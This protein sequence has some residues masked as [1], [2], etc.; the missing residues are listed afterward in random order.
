VGGADLGAD[1]PHGT[2][3]LL[4][5]R[6]RHEDLFDHRS[7]VVMAES[8]PLSFLRLRGRTKS[9][10][11]WVMVILAVGALITAVGAIGSGFRTASGGRAEQL[12]Q[13]AENP[14]VGLMIGVLATVLTQSSTTTTSITVGLAAGGLPIEIAIPILFGANVGTTMTSSLVALGMAKDDVMF[15]RGF[16][17]ASVHDMYN[18]L[19]VAIFFPLELLFSPLERLSGWASA[20][21]SGEEAGP[22]GGIFEAVGTG[23]GYLIRPGVLL[24][25]WAVSPLGSIVGGVILVVAGVLLILAVITF[26]SRMLKQLLVGTA[27]KVFANALGRGAWSGVLSGTIVTMLVQSSTTTTSLAVPF[28]ATGK[29]SLSQIF[30]FVVGANIGTTLTALIAAFGF[31][32]AEGQAALGAALVHLFYNLLSAGLIMLVPWLRRLPPAAAEILARLGTENKLYV[33]GWMLMIFLVI[34][35]ILILLTVFF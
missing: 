11:D 23:V 33:L 12:F 5:C 31:T 28:A 16:A 7:T 20:R 1:V 18:L 13:F 4:K 22:V 24:L 9:V 26:I 34:P 8:Y 14:F 25:E 27:E 17:A 3:H 2:C 35:G 6:L 29:F 15:R 32:G 21:M 10:V 19:S 30:N